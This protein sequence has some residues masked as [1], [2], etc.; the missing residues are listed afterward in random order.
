MEHTVQV[1]PLLE[2]PY[3]ERQLIVVG[4]DQLVQATERRIHS[5]QSKE[6]RGID[7]MQIAEAALAD[8][9]PFPF[10][11][12]EAV[13]KEAIRSWARA[14]ADGVNVIP[15]GK[16]DAKQIDFPPGHPR[17]SVLYVGHPAMPSRYFTM[18]DFHRVVFEHKFCEAIELLMSLGATSI[19]VEHVSGWSRGFS[20]RISV[21]LGV[22]GEPSTGE[23]ASSR[24]KSSGLLFEASL[25]G[26]EPAMPV[27][28]VWYH[29]EPTWQSLAKGRLEFG[30]N[31][32]SMSVL[33]HDDFGINSGLKISLANHKIGLGGTFEDHQS[34][35]WQL[36]GK[37]GAG[38]PVSQVPANDP[39]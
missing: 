3:S 34:T 11:T 9:N 21:P 23:A 19:R 22:V 1:T 30:L 38:S 32:F 36:K 13:A 29:H 39:E 7:W 5:A 10:R 6:T 24:S 17:E 18:A 4:D 8:F 31:D 28:L 35:E 2:M 15:V 14:R 25:P 37:F 16:T 27:G 12:L 33:Y 26:V 20:A